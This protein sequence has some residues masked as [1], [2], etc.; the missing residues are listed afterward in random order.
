MFQIVIAG[1][2]T[3][4]RVYPTCSVYSVSELGLARV[5]MQ[6]MSRS[7]MAD[8]CVYI[9]SNVPRGTLYVGITND[10]VRRTHEHRH[11]LARGFSKR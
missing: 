3:A 4:S 6:S 5:L 2:D 10:L 8:Y 7:A 1:L 11:G 9:L